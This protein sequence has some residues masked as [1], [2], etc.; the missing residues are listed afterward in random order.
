MSEEVRYAETASSWGTR[1]P[2]CRQPDSSPALPFAFPKSRAPG[3]SSIDVRPRPRIR[4]ALL[5][6]VAALTVALPLGQVLRDQQDELQRIASRR[7]AL[8][9]L[10]RAVDLQRGLLAHRDVAGQ[11][12]RGRSAAEPER[13]VRQGDV[14]DRMMTLA[15]SL[16]A[17]PWDRALRESDVMRDDWHA[18]AL[19]IGARRIAADDSDTGH[20]LLVEQL[21]V[22]VDILD[23]ARNVGVADE[24]A[25]DALAAL[26]GLPRQAL[27]QAQ[28]AE[29][30]WATTLQHFDAQVLAA[31][32]ELG[33]ARERVESQRRRLLA[34]IA[35]LGIFG[36]LLALPLLRRRPDGSPPPVAEDEPAA[37]APDKHALAAVLFDRLRDG[38]PTASDDTAQR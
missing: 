11:V 1:G 16:T 22:V 15:V 18:L 4:L 26:H 27:V 28:R 12:L 21:L 8:D 29:R 3:A 30:G 32:R 33:D 20:R 19:R 34:A 9:P 36:L 13:R 7:A 31:A 10:V 6:A 23:A 35:A 17:G 2:K 37:R 24:R 14:D 25:A 38:S 5:A